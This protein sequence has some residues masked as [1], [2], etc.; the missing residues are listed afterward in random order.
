MFLCTDDV[1]NF[2]IDHTHLLSL[3]GRVSLAKQIHTIEHRRNKTLRAGKWMT[4]TAETLG[5]EIEEELS[6]PYTM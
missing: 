3:K 4:L 6:Y 5:M 1:P 2:P